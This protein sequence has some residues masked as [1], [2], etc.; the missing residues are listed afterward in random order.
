MYNKISIT[1][2]VYNEENTIVE[3]YNRIIDVLGNNGYEFEI[4]FVNDGSSDNSGQIMN[5]I[6]DR[7][8]RVQAIHFQQILRFH[9]SGFFP[10]ASNL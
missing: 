8:Y 2:P 9:T 5:D 6:A 3:L 7:D 4:I 1:I 10:A